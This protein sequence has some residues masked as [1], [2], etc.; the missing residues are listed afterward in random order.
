MR[1]KENGQVL[2]LLNM[3]NAPDEVRRKRRQVSADCNAEMG[4][5]MGCTEVGARNCN[6]QGG[7]RRLQTTVTATE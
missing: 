7:G 1:N 6:K 3:A 5:G 4:T 2:A